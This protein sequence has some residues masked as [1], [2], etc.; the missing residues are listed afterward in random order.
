MNKVKT[1]CWRIL[2]LM[3]TE[4][5]FPSACNIFTA[6]IIVYWTK[7]NLC[8]YP[9]EVFHETRG[10]ETGFGIVVNSSDF[11]AFENYLLSCMKPLSNILL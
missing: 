8:L 4:T 1:I 9:L 2:S 10:D 7:C 3:K 5:N 11:S 6:I